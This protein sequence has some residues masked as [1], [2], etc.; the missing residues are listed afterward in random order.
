MKAI[1]SS[2]RL[3][4]ATLNGEADRVAELIE[5]CHS[6][7]TSVLQYNDENSLACTITIAYYSARNKYIMHRELAT[8]KGFA[9]IIFIPM[10]NVDAPAIV[11][12]LKHNKTSGAAIEQ[13]KNKKYTEK[14]AQYTGEILLVG[15]NY[16]DNKGHICEIEKFVKE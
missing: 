12:E 6:E 7:N 5:Q 1:Q 10:R 14:I 3:L 2:D 15:I 16:D 8:G 11:V 4:E 13:I 9:D